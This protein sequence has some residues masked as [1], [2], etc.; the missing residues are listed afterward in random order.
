MFP[1]EPTP[2]HFGILRQLTRQGHGTI[3]LF[4]ALHFGTAD[5]FPLPDNLL[6]AYRTARTVAF[7]TDLGELASPAFNNAM[8]ELGSQPPE[9]SLQ[10]DLSPKIWQDLLSVAESLG[11]YETT[12]AP[13]KPWYCASLLTSAALRQAGLSSYLG[14]DA[15]L[16]RQAQQDDKD[17]LCLETPQR[18][19]DLLSQI[20]HK[21]NDDFIR[22][23]IAELRDMPSFSAKM[24]RL[25]LEQ[26]AEALAEL[27]ADG[28]ADNSDLQQNMLDCRNRL[29]YQKLDQAAHNGHH[30]LAVVGAGHLVGHASLVELFRSHG[31][32]CEP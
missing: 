26:N 22:Q 8:R 14:I 10:D 17:I 28:F 18:Q 6:D 12:L 21:T 15:F 5:M 3:T 2:R 1:T 29:W 19:L 9:H 20:N 30:V 25:W 11:Y 16:F 32:A 13:C 24:L 7:E 23:T 31:Y 4:G 27:I